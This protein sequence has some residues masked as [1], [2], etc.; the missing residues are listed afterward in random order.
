MSCKLERVLTK[1]WF[2]IIKPFRI[3][4]VLEIMYA[5][6]WCYYLILS[7]LPT[8][9]VSGSLFTALRRSLNPYV[10]I[11]LFLQMAVVSSVG[12]LFNIIVIRKFVLMVNIAI[13]AWL[14]V[15]S[16]S[17]FPISGGIGYIVILTGLTIFVFLRIDALSTT[18]KLE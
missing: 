10:V 9:L 3:A 1:A 11:F 12:L 17:Q 18:T 2:F 7:F 15:V 13:M 16:I 8:N 6:N 14:I 5:L 4:Q